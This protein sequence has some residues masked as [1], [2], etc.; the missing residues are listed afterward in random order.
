MKKVLTLIMLVAISAFIGSSVQAAV[1][2]DFNAD[3]EGWVGE[4][5]GF[6]VPAV[7]WTEWS[8]GTLEIN[9]G[10]C[11][12]NHDDWA[13]IYVKVEDE[14]DLTQTPK[15]DMD[16]YV[17]GN[18]YWAKA[19]INVLT[20]DNWQRY[21]STS[22]DLEN[23][24]S[25]QHLSCDFSQAAD[26]DY[27]RQIGLELEGFMSEDPKLNLDNVEVSAVPEPGSLILMA[28]GLIGLLG[29]G[30]RKLHK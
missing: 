11:T 24:Y 25:W 1:L 20:G 5:W 22:I 12:V 10:P 7:S 3:T 28:S 14:M 26:L 30:T 27:V 8:G 6:G 21:Q 9:T 13:K 23:N 4:D 2:Y 19:K 17:P 16:V 15:I 18:I 29:M